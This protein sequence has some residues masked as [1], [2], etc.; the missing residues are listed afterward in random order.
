MTARFASMMI[1]ALTSAA[2]AQAPAA[3]PAAGGVKMVGSEQ[4]APAPVDQTA[5]PL[6]FDTAFHDF[7]NIDDDKPVE[8]KFTFRNSGI[9]PV[10][11]NNIRTSCGCS[12]A[13][14][15]N[16]KRVYAPGETGSMKVTFDPRGRRGEERKTVTIETDSLANPNIELR[17]RSLVVPQMLIEPTTI[18]F[19]EVPILDQ[20]RTQEFSIA[21]RIAGFEIKGMTINHPQAKI[22]PIGTDEVD[23]G[24]QKLKRNRYRV[25]MPTGLA[26]GNWNNALVIQTNNPAQPQINVPMLAIVVGDVRTTPERVFVRMSGQGQPWQGDVTV[27]TR[28]TQPFNIISAEPYDVPPEMRMVID[29]QPSGPNLR[30]SYRVRAAGLTPR[31]ITDIKGG[32]RLRTDLKD[33]PVVDIPL[34]GMWTGPMQPQTIPGVGGGPK[35]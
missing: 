4:A 25:T 1:L 7:G 20:G 10:T 21:S 28:N 19:G 18:F 11:I 6:K 26:L 17:L 35:Q 2:L 23:M 12:A 14:P 13:T 31:L 27:S 30:N 34:I 3:S 16:D 32:V 9:A 8:F 22:E 5:W 15:D 33:M 29:L 24:G